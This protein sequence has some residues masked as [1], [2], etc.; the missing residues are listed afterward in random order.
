MYCCKAK[1]SG[2]VPDVIFKRKGQPEREKLNGH[3]FGLEWYKDG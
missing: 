1:L 3:S 2:N